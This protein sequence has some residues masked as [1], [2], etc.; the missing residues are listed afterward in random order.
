[1]GVN[2]NVQKSTMK[3]IRRNG[4]SRLSPRSIMMHSVVGF[5]CL[6]IIGLLLGTVTLER[7]LLQQSMVSKGLQSSVTG[8]NA[9]AETNVDFMVGKLKAAENELLQKENELL[10]QEKMNKLMIEQLMMKIKRLEFGNADASMAA[11]KSKNDVPANT[12]ADKRTLVAPT[13][14]KPAAITLDKNGRFVVP[15]HF[16]AEQDRID[17]AM[18]ISARCAQY[19]SS[20]LPAN[21][22]KRR[23]F[24]GSL[25]AYENPEVFLAH[26]IE[27]Y[28]LYDVVALIESST[29][30]RGTYRNMTYQPGS[31]RA[32]E[33]THSELFGTL[34]K[35]RVVLDYWLKDLPGLP[36]M[37][38]EE[39]QRKR[40]TETWIKEGM[41]K[42]DV[43][44]L[45][46]IDEF[47]SRDALIALRLCDFPQFR[48]VEDPDCLTPKITLASVQFEATPLCIK[49]KEWYHP[50]LIPGHC[51]EG[52]G[53]P[54]GRPIPP[55]TISLAKALDPSLPAEQ[56]TGPKV[57]GRRPNEWGKK[58]WK[59]YPQHVKDSGRYPL[60]NA[61][62]IRTISGTNGKNLNF[63]DLWPKRQHGTTAFFGAAYHLHNWF[64]DITSLRHK[65]LTYGHW[66]SQAEWRPLSLVTHDLG[67]M[68]R[69][70]NNLGNEWH[71]ENGTVLQVKDLQAGPA[72]LYFENNRLLPE[73]FKRLRG[74]EQ[75]WG[76]LGGNRPIFFS[77]RT[78]VVH[79]HN[80]V[81]D[82]VIADEE[83][84]GRFFTE[85]DKYMIPK[86]P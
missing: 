10:Q 61:G 72:V 75:A 31:K 83:K 86:K 5:A 58:H 63:Q 60:W 80:L 85:K 14:P 18:D 77:N 53:D 21:A 33:L 4:K 19:G 13:N 57:F 44:L 28:N 40:I 29:T 45:A 37:E 84:F 50:D 23:I 62:D 51:L 26:A 11:A 16:K 17:S 71:A 49:R 74:E 27:T 56:D 64:V 82:M 36:S 35:T 48:H 7:Q 38:R 32:L 41:T 54:T 59:S 65:Y 1:M 46:D 30:F 25:V 68:A 79:R 70:V 9:A 55:R 42:H 22:T 52:I 8:R 15:P 66:H 69:C 3:N 39:E 34:D 24:F 2:S 76:T 47:P 81:K 12:N 6:Y 20:P 78:Y 67:V 73:D 43:G